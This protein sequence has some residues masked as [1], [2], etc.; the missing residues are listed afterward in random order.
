MS[1]THTRTGTLHRSTD[2]SDDI[3]SMHDVFSDWERRAVL[4]YLQER[5]DPA[6][7]DGIVTHLVDW[8]RGNEEATP[9]E[10]NPNER[11]RHRVVYAHVTKMDDFGIVSYDSRADTVSLCDDMKV[12]VSPPWTQ[13]SGRN[14]H[15][16]D[17]GTS[18]RSSP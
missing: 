12:S 6:E 18:G 5:E 7:I 16:P 10:G 14:E 3:Q 8:R 17:L 11:T 4:Y 15:G 9:R 2:D 1:D 13:A